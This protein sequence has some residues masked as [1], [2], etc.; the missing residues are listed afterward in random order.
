MIVTLGI[1]PTR[2]EPALGY[3]RIGA[4]LG[5]EFGGSARGIHRVSRFVEKPDLKR[6]RQFVA[7]GNYLW[8]AGIFICRARVFLE[9]LAEHAPEI[10]KPLASL[11]TAPVRGKAAQAAVARAYRR[12]PSEAVD[13]AIM[14]RSR[15]VWC[16]PVTF[17]WSD[18]GTW[19]SLAEE[20]GVDQNVTK[21]IDGEALLCDSKGNLIRAQGRPVILLGVSGLAVIDAGDAILIADLERSGGSGQDPSTLA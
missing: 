17:R 7:K 3:I 21:V 10:S 13:K 8:N 11:A 19:K 14:E 15:R 12:T 18:V 5:A 6:A 20:L 1:R 2:P 16:L 4:E 9:E